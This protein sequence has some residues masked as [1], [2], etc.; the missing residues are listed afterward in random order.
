MAAEPE[1]AEFR[2]QSAASRA[3]NDAETPPHRRR[4]IGHGV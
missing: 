2:V 3:G 4:G 1:S